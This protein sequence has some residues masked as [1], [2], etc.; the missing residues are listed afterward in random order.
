VILNA[1]TDLSVQQ[2]QLTTPT[3]PRMQM[4]KP[5]TFTLK[6]SE[7]ES[8]VLAFL[9]LQGCSVKGCTKTATLVITS[10][11]TVVSVFRA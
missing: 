2:G 6:W 10:A 11:I 7:M 3:I 8:T 1:S 5:W 9:A 4:E